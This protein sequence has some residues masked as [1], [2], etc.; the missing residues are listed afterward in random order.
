MST[1]LLESRVSKYVSIRTVE[2]QIGSTIFSGMACANR[3]IIKNPENRHA[4]ERKVNV[5]YA[6]IFCYQILENTRKECDM[7][8]N[9]D[10]VL[11]LASLPL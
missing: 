11:H 10:N 5:S 7:K 3:R 4:V 1:C 9:V 8:E 2:N 6:F